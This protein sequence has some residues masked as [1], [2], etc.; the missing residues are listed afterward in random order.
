MSTHNIQLQYQK[1]NCTKFSQ[2]CSYKIFPMGLK[3]EF[4]TAIKKSSVFKPL[5][6]Y[7]IF[8]QINETFFLV[9]NSLLQG[10]WVYLYVFLPFVQVKQL[11]DFLFA[12][13]DNKAF[14]KCRLVLQETKCFKRSKL[15]FL[16]NFDPPPTPIPPPPTPTPHIGQGG[17][18]ENSRVFSPKSTYSP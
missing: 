9:G 7:C 5:K 8:F 14:P 10:L 1:E 12:S 13:L 11:C 17:K 18:T 15:F 6:F 16:K 4:E 2:I 3:N